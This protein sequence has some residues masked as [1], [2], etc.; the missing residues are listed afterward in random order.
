MDISTTFDT[1]QSTVARQFRTATTHH[2][3]TQQN[4][5]DGLIELRLPATGVKVAE[6]AGD[7]DRFANVRAEAYWHLRTLFETGQIMIPEDDELIN[8]LTQLKYKIVNSNGTI[9]LEENE[10]MKKRLGK[11][12]DLSDSLCL[13]YYEPPAGVAFDIGFF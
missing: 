8:E 3:T 6:K 10:E 11:S 7:F 5:V 1:R 9:R 4:L 13:A 2:R 12:P